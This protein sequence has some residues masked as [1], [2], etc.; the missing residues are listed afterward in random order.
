MPK[1]GQV[2]FG[3]NYFGDSTPPTANWKR[4]LANIPLGVRVRRQIGKK[5]IFRIR[6]GNGHAGAIAGIAYQDKYKYVVPSNI[7]NAKSTPYRTHWK[8]AVDYWQ[9][10]LSSDEKLTYNKRA[11][12]GLRMSGYNLFM[13][14]AMNG[15][16]QMFVHRGD[17]ATHDFVKEDLTIDGAWHN[18]DISAIVPA[19][20]RA[21]L[22]RGQ[23]EGN[24][25]DWLV[26][27]RKYGDTNE[28][29]VCCLETLRANIARCRLCVGAVDHNRIIQYKIDNQNWTT[30]NLVVRG[31]WT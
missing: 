17:P 25:A 4:S 2:H 5:V 21:V 3:R 22:W 8:A 31:W 18:L 24:G 7:N 9:N 23:V 27:F 20:A 10:I 14:E 16:I 15:E 1:F 12:K 26:L 29:N 30:I 6:R 19:T 13:R 11:T 28:I